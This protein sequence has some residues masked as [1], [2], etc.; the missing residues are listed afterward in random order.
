MKEAL[1]SFLFTGFIACG[2]AQG[3]PKD[4]IIAGTVVDSLT[5]KPVEFANVVI[6]DPAT[7]KPINGAVCNDVGK[8]VVEKTKK[9]NYQ[10]VISF[11]GYN[12]KKISLVISEKKSVTNL[13]TIILAPSVE[14]LKEVVIEGQK[15]L[16]E[17]KVDRTVY[18][19]E[20]DATTKGGDATD[21]LKRVPM[22]SVDMDGNVSLKGSSSVRVLINNRPSTISATSVA[23]A[24]KQIPSDMIKSVEVITSPSAMYDAEGSAGII[25]I[26]LKKNTLEGL[27]INADGSA[28][29][30]GSNAGGNVSYKQ[31]KMGFS[32]GAFQRWQYNQIS[33]FD[34]EQ[35]TRSDKDTLKNVQ[36]NHNR[37]D[38]AITQYT[39]NWDYDIN[40]NNLLN[41]SM[42]YGVRNQ[43]TY[44]DNLLTDT[45][46]H[47]SLINSTLR[48]VKTI[49]T[50]ANLDGSIGYTRDFS[51]KGRQLNMLAI[52]SRNDQNSDYTAETVA[53]TK[54]SDLNRYR[55]ENRGF[56]QES[57]IQ[58]DF[59]EPLKNNQMLEFG[60]KGTF[61]K[62]LSDYHYYVAQGSDG[63]FVPNPSP[64]LTNNFNYDQRISAAYFAYSFESSRGWSAKAG[65]RYE[66]TSI[67]AHFEGQPDISIPSYGVLVPSVNISR[68]LSNGRLIRASYNRRI[69]RPWLQALNPNLQAS[70]SL[71]ATQ[72]NPNLQPEYADNYE[73][74]YRT[75]IPKGT[76]NVSTY[77]RYNTNDIQPVRMLK[78]DTIVA[79]Y[80]N[81]G[82]EANYGVAA[83]ASINFTEHLLVSG[84][85]DLI[86]RILNNNSPDPILNATNSGL[87]QNYRVTGIYSFNKGWQAQL[88]FG[89]QGKNYNLQGYRTGVNT[90]SLAIR[91]DIF[92]KAGSLGVGVDNFVTPSFNVY[93]VVN[94]PFVIQHT[95]TTLYNLIFKINF[96]YKI[97]RQLQEKVRKLKAE[98]NE[99]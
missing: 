62:V 84:G 7:G 41:A 33:D 64:Y 60:G 99:N 1:Y 40:K 8:F 16:V 54:P 92:N 25:N 52:Y 48:N 59:Q 10:F 88:F 20:Q 80:Q 55:N 47:D 26:V 97:G 19:A 93:N 4:N 44:Q 78:G 5:Q 86:Y 58:I 94:S 56:N 2:Y 74:A 75:N 81:L 42:R 9:G 18:N 67:A 79:T 39:L 32:L 43:N 85:I 30:R 83:F 17:E 61:R 96:T 22:L 24:L 21:V 98:E 45:Y 34:N 70:N 50:G 68:K 73:I 95:T 72:G 11:I 15:M 51:K 76:L 57:S 38:G 37:S 77:L 29:T 89:F 46:R 23:D 13:G 91:K 69:V 14:M 63:P 35:I 66:Y 65:G 53:A 71:N 28:G 90:Q 82:S 27:F 31:G 12:S 36:S 3:I 87:T 49:G 6:V